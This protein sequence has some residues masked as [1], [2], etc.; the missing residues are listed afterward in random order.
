[1]YELVRIIHVCCTSDNF[2]ACLI[3]VVNKT[4]GGIIRS[5]WLSSSEDTL[6]EKKK[7]IYIFFFG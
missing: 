4:S 1:M 7:Y 5:S 3:S 2:S 6:P